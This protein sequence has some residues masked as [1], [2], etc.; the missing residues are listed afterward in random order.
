[1]YTLDNP[2][3]VTKMSRDVYTLSR[4]PLIYLYR[5]VI[6]HFCSPKEIKPH[7]RQPSQKIDW[8]LY[9]WMG[10]SSFGQIFSASSYDADTFLSF[11]ITVYGL[12]LFGD[13][14]ARMQV[15]FCYLS[16]LLDTL[17]SQNMYELIIFTSVI[18]ARLVCNVRS[19]KKTNK[20]QGRE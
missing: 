11:V 18:L 9:V 17:V 10:C 16:F 2:S 4:T 1:M 3:G 12:V 8:F 20:G 19:K 15:I 14:L 13:L 5:C 6:S 7:M